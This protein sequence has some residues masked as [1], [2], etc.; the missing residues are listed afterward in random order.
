MAWETEGN[1]YILES[2]RGSSDPMYP[3]YL[4]VP[5]W[6][7]H[8]LFSLISVLSALCPLWSEVSTHS[9][10]QA[11]PTF[12]ITIHSVVAS[13]K[14]SYRAAAISHLIFYRIFF[15]QKI[16]LLFPDSFYTWCYSMPL[17]YQERNPSKY[18]KQQRVFTLK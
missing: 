12:S 17:K 15:T 14:C 11:Y 13:F 2:A 6:F 4:E 7:C 5:C 9:Q 8:Q 1:E 18:H 16:P 3:V 10:T